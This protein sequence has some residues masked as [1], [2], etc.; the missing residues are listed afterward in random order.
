MKTVISGIVLLISIFMCSTV[1]NAASEIVTASGS[2]CISNSSEDM[3]EVA[4]QK[5]R[6]YAVKSASEKA[7]YYIESYSKS[8]NFLLTNDELNVVTGNVFNVISEDYKEEKIDND[9]KSIYTCIIKAEV[10]T[11]NIDYQKIKEF[12]KTSGFNLADYYKMNLSDVFQQNGGII[13]SVKRESIHYDKEGRLCLTIVVHSANAP[14]LCVLE[15]VIDK[16]EKKYMTTSAKMLDCKTGEIISNEGANLGVGIVNDYNDGSIVQNAVDYVKFEENKLTKDFVLTHIVE[17]RKFLC[18]LANHHFETKNNLFL[19]NHMIDKSYDGANN[20]YAEYFLP[21]T[22]NKEGS[23]VR[24]KSIE[25]MYSTNINPITELEQ[26]N[27]HDLN[28]YFIYDWEFNTSKNTASKKKYVV[29]NVQHKIQEQ[30]KED[31]VIDIP[32]AM[33]PDWPLMYNTTCDFYVFG[34]TFL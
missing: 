6:S 11:D 14:D 20:I 9:D 2:Y 26:F 17:E 7:G 10:N 25:M 29:Y 13:Y 32:S 22:I 18:E 23:I 31:L 3:I 21:D 15:W 19:F 34:K 28:A 4:K 30:Q 1:A 24:L 5:A 16:V 12:R 8:N 27:L 33:S